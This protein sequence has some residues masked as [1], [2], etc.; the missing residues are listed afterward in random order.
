MR[1]KDPH[2]AVAQLVNEIVSIVHEKLLDAKMEMQE[3]SSNDTGS[4][5]LSGI[6]EEDSNVHSAEAHLSPN[7]TSARP[8]PHPSSIGPVHRLPGVTYPLRRTASEHSG[9]HMGPKNDSKSMLRSP[10]GT[11]LAPEAAGEKEKGPKSVGRHNFPKSMFYIWKKDSFKSNYDTLDGDSMEDR[12]PLNPE[13]ATRAY[14]QRRNAMVQ[15]KGRKQ[16]ERFLE[17]RPKPPETTKALDL[18]LD[19]DEEADNKIAALKGELKLTESRLLKNSGVKMTSLLNFHSYEDV[20]MVCDDQDGISVWDYEKGSRLLSYKNGNPQGSRMTSSFWINEQTKSLFLVG[21]DDGS[22]RVWNGLVD[23]RGSTSFTCPMLSA[24]FFAVPDMQAG[25]RGSGLI[26]EWQQ[27]SESLIAGGSSRQIRYW[28]LSTEKCVRSFET[29]TD[30]VVTTLTT[31]WEEELGTMQGVVHGIGPDIIVSGHSDG[32]LRLFDVRCS[33]VWQ[34]LVGNPDATCNS[35]NTEVGLW[36][37]LSQHTVDDTKL[38]QEAWQVTFVLG[39]CEA[40][41]ASDV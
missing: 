39:I 32:S 9:S 40:L 11:A 12:D 33:M 20:L 15:A 36:I 30:A 23:E 37:L 6:A 21:A 35:R 3:V 19:S 31:A 26:C 28:D 1:R 4:A 5:G 2:P 38:C 18:L 27:Y 17:L 41:V 25:Q 24:A 16:G 13:G 14:Q 34:G 29:G 8:K 7:V 22:V 10:P